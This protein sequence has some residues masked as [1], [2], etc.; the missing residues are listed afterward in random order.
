MGEF[1]RRPLAIL[2]GIYRFV[3]GLR[4]VNRVDLTSDLTLVHDVS[5]QAE[6][7]GIGGYFGNVFWEGTVSGNGTIE[8]MITRPSDIQPALNLDSEYY[9]LWVMRFAARTTTAD[10][11]DFT[12]F[13]VY[14]GRDG[15]SAGGAPRLATLVGS[16]Q[17]WSDVLEEF[18]GF[19]GASNS[20]GTTQPSVGSTFRPVR[21]TP[22]GFLGVQIVTTAAAVL[23]FKVDLW[24][25]PLGSSPPGVS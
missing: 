1:T 7:A 23:Y 2:D 9:E 25:G 5:R 19:S 20:A 15:T 3:G 14:Q 12:S 10:E 4:G 21:T 24:A 6:K 11:G 13:S 8:E 18:T 22:G 16:A 17:V